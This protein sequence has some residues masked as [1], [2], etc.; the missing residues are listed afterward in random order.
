[1][2]ILNIKT[3]SAKEVWKS[4]D[5]QRTIF[6]LIVDYKGSP[7]K[8]KTY[9]GAIATEGWEGAVESYEKEGRNGSET[10]VK[11]P[12]KE[13]GFQSGASTSSSSGSKPAY[14]PKDEKAIQ[15]MWAISQSI[16]YNKADTK[17]EEIAETAKDLF[18]MVDVVKSASA[19][20]AVDVNDEDLAKL[21]EI[22]TEKFQVIDEE[23]PQIGGEEAWKK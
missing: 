20:D 22:F 18:L 12:P 1:M 2:P 7:L 10:F 21:D 23:I 14:V 17:I 6:E 11:Q 15:A 13:G 4:P 9:S 16:A 3:T 5:G 19:G 8:A